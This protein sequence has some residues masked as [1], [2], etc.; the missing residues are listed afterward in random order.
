[1]IKEGKNGASNSGKRQTTPKMAQ[2]LHSMRGTAILRGPL[3]L[4]WVHEEQ[5]YSH[6][7]N[8]TG[9]ACYPSKMTIIDP[10]EF[11]WLELR[12][13][14]IYVILRRQM[15]PPNWATRPI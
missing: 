3:V 12:V 6:T 14:M 7:L 2:S 11:L 15:S 4:L 1:M 13:Y 8:E 5:G 10:N 9:V